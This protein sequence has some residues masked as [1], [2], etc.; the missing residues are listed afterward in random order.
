ILPEASDA[1]I[2]L[3]DAAD[4]AGANTEELV[5]ALEEVGIAADGT[6]DSLSDYL[7]LLFATGLAAMSERDAHAKYQES[8]RG[9]GDAVDELI[10]E[11]GG[12][13]AALNDSKTDFDI[14]TEA[15]KLA[16]DA[17]HTVAQ[18]ALGAADA[19]AENGAS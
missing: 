9:V 8:L 10:K 5:G 2:G 19:M 13:S 1:T 7:D 16:Q 6:V 11:H 3:D 17:F 4:G 18:D 12:L 14:T 15:G